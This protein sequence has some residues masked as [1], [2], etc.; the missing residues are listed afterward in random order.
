MDLII[1]LDRGRV[2]E[3]GSHAELLARGGLY[4]RLWHKQSGLR[5]SADLTRVEVEPGRLRAI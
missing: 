5:V 1:V 2:S 4:A 3:Q